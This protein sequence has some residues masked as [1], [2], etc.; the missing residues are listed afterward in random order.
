M[1]IRWVDHAS[2][3]ELAERRDEAL[4]ATWPEFMHHDAVC[5]AEW[6]HLYDDFPRHQVYL[7]DEEAGELLGVGNSIPFWW[8]G[9]AAGLPEGVDGVLLRAVADLRAERRPN[10]LSALLAVVAERR[11]GRRLGARLLEAMA[12]A[13]RAAGLGPMVAPV[14]PTQKS[15]YPLQP[16]GRYVAW[17]RPDGSHFD[18]WIRL[19]EGIGGRILGVVVRSMAIRGSVAEWESWTGL[20]LPES[21]DYVVPG[22]LVP[23]RVDRERD[24]A[25]YLEPNVWMLHPGEP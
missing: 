21:G 22:A 2:R 1:S 23:V 20:A 6:H 12:E 19:H 3:P 4:G 18:P 5:Q 14:R 9:S 15:R 16:M 25:V 17:R 7:L 11:R 10:T 13:G 24:E 8:D